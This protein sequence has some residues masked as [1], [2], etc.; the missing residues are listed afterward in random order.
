MIAKIISAAALVC[1]LAFM[2]SC[3]SSKGYGC[4]NHINEPPHSYGS[5]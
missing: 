2:S 5:R 3:A 4:K 1:A